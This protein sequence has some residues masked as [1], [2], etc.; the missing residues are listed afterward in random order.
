MNYTGVG[1]LFFLILSVAVAWFVWEDS[2]S[3]TAIPDYSTTKLLA[4]QGDGEAQY[5]LGLLLL[6]GLGVTSDPEEAQQWF[7][8]SADSG[9]AHAQFQVSQFHDRKFQSSENPEHGIKAFNWLK[10]ACDKGSWEAQTKMGQI[11]LDGL[12]IEGLEVSPDQGTAAFWFRRAAKNGSSNANYQLAKLLDANPKL[13]K[14]GEESLDYYKKAAE[15]GNPDA[16]Y[17]LGVIY[18]EGKLT[19]RNHGLAMEW[20]NKAAQQGQPYAEYMVATE[21]EREGKIQEALN[22]YARSAEQGFAE[23]HYKIGLIYRFD[24]LIDADLE[25]AEFHLTKA[26]ELGHSKAK[27][28]RIG[29]LAEQGDAE[30]QYYFGNL[31]KNRYFDGGARK[32]FLHDQAYVWYEKSA[33]QGYPA[34]QNEMGKHLYLGNPEKAFSLYRQ[35][36]HQGLSPAQWNLAIMYMKGEATERDRMTANMWRIISESTRPAGDMYSYGRM[37]ARFQFAPLNETEM[38][39]VQA[40][41]QRCMETDYE[42]CAGT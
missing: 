7:Q 25:K 29:L 40:L 9:N 26:T 35:A 36:A 22:Y 5:Q 42:V 13:A 32:S 15:Q 41:A 31:L 27:E 6:R 16:Q 23:A 11:Y 34:A 12:Q 3:S 21:L 14:N 30:N 38:A 17:W 8:K 2:D 20:M 4:E 37:S 39:E 24:T 1:S 33:N 28:E 19:R 18:L 10:K